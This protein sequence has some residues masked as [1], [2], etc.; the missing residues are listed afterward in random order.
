MDDSIP[1][2]ECVENQIKQV[3]IN[4]IKNGLDSM[5]NGGMFKILLKNE[6]KNEVSIS[7]ID[8]G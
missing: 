1:L 4:L 3:F 5:D 2:I 7:F 6:L 8:Q